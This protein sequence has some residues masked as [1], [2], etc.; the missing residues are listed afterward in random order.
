MANSF[1][2]HLSFRIRLIRK[3]SKLLSIR[4]LF[5]RFYKKERKDAWFDFTEEQKISTIKQLAGKYPGM[6]KMEEELKAI[7]SFPQT[8]YPAAMAAERNRQA[9]ETL[10][11]NLMDMVDQTY[12]EYGNL[13]V[14][15]G[16]TE[17]EVAQALKDY[18]IK[19]GY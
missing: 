6:V 10:N 7:K 16:L 9:I 4:N 19:N 1:N 18:R 11:P 8:H 12:R 15:P 3:K 5:S 13:I 2:Q 17:Q 14:P